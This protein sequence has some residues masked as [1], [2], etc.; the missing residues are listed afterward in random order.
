MNLKGSDAMYIIYGTEVQN[1]F[2]ILAD[3]R[4]VCDRYGM[5]PKT[6]KRIRQFPDSATADMVLKF[7]EPEFDGYE[8]H[9]IHFYRCLQ[10]YRSYNQIPTP[11]DDCAKHPEIPGML[12]ELAKVKGAEEPA[13]QAQPSPV[14]P[15][16]PAPQEKPLPPE[17]SVSEVLSVPTIRL[18]LPQTVSFYTDGS[19]CEFMFGGFAAIPLDG[20]RPI[21]FLSGSAIVHS[22]AEAEWRAIHLALRSLPEGNHQVYLYTDSQ[23]VVTHLDNESYRGAVTQSPEMRDILKEIREICQKNTV[24]IT[25]VSGHRGIEW[26]ELADVIAKKRAGELRR[27]CMNLHAPAKT[28]SM[29]CNLADILDSIPS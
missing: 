19:C 4:S 14:L 7:T 3:Y 15:E 12:E 17:A 20:G 11:E 16:E 8:K 21:A 25:H 18:C 28:D 10:A 6:G 9:L 27:K 26:N 13:G 5:L 2:D 22:S 24:S 1:G 29:F 23:E